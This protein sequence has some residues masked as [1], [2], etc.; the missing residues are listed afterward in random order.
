MNLVNWPSCCQKAYETAFYGWQADNHANMNPT[1]SGSLSGELR[2]M[3]PVLAE[4]FDEARVAIRVVNRSTLFDAHV[5]KTTCTKKHTVHVALIGSNLLFLIWRLVMI[6]GAACIS[7][8][9]TKTG[10]RYV[11]REPND[12]DLR[13]LGLA[14]ET[15]LAGGPLDQQALDDVAESIGKAPPLARALFVQTATLAE[16]FVILHEVAHVLPLPGVDVSLGE[17]VINPERGAAWLDELKADISAYEMLLLGIMSGFKDQ[18]GND[19]RHT[20]MMKQDART[21]AFE[22]VACAVASVHA[23]LSLA[24]R[25]QSERLPEFPAVIDPQFRTHPPLFI[26]AQMFD[27]WIKSRAQESNTPDGRVLADLVRTFTSQLSDRFFSDDK[28]H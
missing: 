21:Y 13:Q 27:T 16:L 15:Y 18:L 8:E 12:E 11:I 2:S 19:D 28:Q 23:A 26:R 17:L 24:I 7:A 20:E 9:Q 1:M 3:L 22:L 14:F 5:L 4:V 10:F 6:T 25:K